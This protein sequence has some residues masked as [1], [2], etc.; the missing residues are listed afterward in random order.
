M[1][2]DLLTGLVQFNLAVGAAIALVLVMRQPLRRAF[3][4]RV[5]YALWLLVPLAGAASL[6]PARQV[7]PIEP[8]PLRPLAEAAAE[9]IDVALAAAPIDGAQALA[10]AV[11]VVGALAALG[12]MA[13]RQ[14]ASLS[15]LGRLLPEAG[16]LVRAANPAVGPAV[17]GVMRPR[18]IVPADFEDRFDDRERTV[19]LAHERAHLAAWDVRVNAAA[20]LAR[21]ILWFNP[22]IHLAAGLIRIDQEIACDETVV[23]RHPTERRAYAQAL[24]K[25]QVKPAPLPLGCYW[26]ARSR[27]R[28]KERVLMLTRK[29]PTRGRLT[30]GAAVVALAGLGAGYAAWA[31]QPAPA[32]IEAAAPIAAPL[33]APLNHVIQLAQADAPADATP[34]V[35]KRVV[36]NKDGVTQTFEGDAI[37]ADI[38]AQI[39]AAQAAGG[40]H[41]VV[42]IIRHGD[43]DAALALDNDVLVR[44]MI[45]AGGSVHTIKVRCEKTLADAEPVCTTLEG[46]P[47]EAA[48]AIEKLKAEGVDGGAGQHVFV[49]R[50][51]Q[52]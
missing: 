35:V 20:A 11:W 25:A 14:W 51:E 45:E 33:A 2:A 43:G 15:L 29:S 42:K 40:A 50:H 17:V 44:K 21:C 3:G 10:I 13:W 38:Q 6:L 41:K 48:A 26:P 46:D 9:R 22:L 27:N 31:A 24:L 5:A 16:G 28:L 8:A 39:D 7:L 49:L 34:H 4:A 18:I 47:A 36:I 19:I 1:P 32:L 30:A 23:A 37:P 52:R 12:L